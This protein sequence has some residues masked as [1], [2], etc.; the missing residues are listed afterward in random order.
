[1][2]KKKDNDYRFVHNMRTLNWVIVRDTATPLLHENYA[3]DF[4]ELSCVRSL[5]LCNGY[6]QYPLHPDSR[7]LTALQTRMGPMR[8]ATLPQGASNS[9][10]TFQ[11]AAN[12]ITS[13]EDPSTA[14]AY[15]D[16][17]GPKGPRTKYEATDGIAETVPGN[18]GVRRYIYENLQ[19]L[20]RLLWK[21][22]KYGRT[23][24]GKKVRLCD[25]VQSIVGFSWSYLGR[26][27]TE[28]S[29]D[30]IT[31]WPSCANVKE[32]RGFLGTVGPAGNWIRNYAVVARLLVRVAAGKIQD[33][34][35]VWTKEAD[36]AFKRVKDNV[37]G[38][39]WMRPVDYR[40]SEEV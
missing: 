27:P 29:I 40:S 2:V 14:V 21:M 37:S 13:D 25:E 7:K 22:G 35:E 3:D 26:E 31:I 23:F 39:A 17:S 36:E 1:M 38:R 32:V 12:S 11:R 20:H 30:K 18:P 33:P 16:E 10:G 24:S 8:L 9:A 15:L 5:D 34:D 28:T 19:A 6:G 4:A